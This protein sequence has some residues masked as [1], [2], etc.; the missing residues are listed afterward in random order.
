MST[1]QLLKNFFNSLPDSATGGKDPGSAYVNRAQDEE[2]DPVAKLA[3]YIQWED[4]QSGCYLFSGL[5]GSGKT[6]ELNRLVSE[7]R[8][9]N[10]AAYYCDASTYLNL[11]H[12]ELT[13]VELLMTVLAGLADA[14]KHDLGTEFL[15]ESIWQRM[16][17]TLGGVELKPKIKVPLGG[18][19]SLEVEATL[20]ENPDFRSKLIQFAQQSSEFFD[21]AQT[22]VEEMAGCIRQQK[23]CKKIVLV[24][25]SLERLSAP[26][27]DESKLFDSLK[28]IFFNEPRRLQLPSISVVYSAPPYLSAVL[29]NVSAG[30]SEMVSL[31]NFKVSQK[32]ESNQLAIPNQDGIQRM[33]SILDARFAGWQSIIDLPVAEHLAWMS[34][35]NV[36]NYFRLLRTVAMKAALGKVTLPITTL[37]ATPVVHALNDMAQPIQWLSGA[38]RQW[39]KH[40]MQDTRPPAEH[41]QDLSTDLPSIIRLFDHSLVL[42]YQNGSVW[43]QVP[44]LVRNHVG[45]T[46]V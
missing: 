29:P 4:V 31:P 26:Q 18:T 40:F 32:P 42:D 41:I 13:L 1:Q 27:G 22:F 38:D 2:H 34:G 30:F 17:R 36:R 35:G 5:R 6:T 3:T 21:E 28:N 8:Q 23:S 12:P 39:L 15:P 43:Y 37:E 14:V 45:T 10:I 11:N 44:P 46:L 16:R 20:H 25:D 33:I 19:A 7:L 24:V 9:E